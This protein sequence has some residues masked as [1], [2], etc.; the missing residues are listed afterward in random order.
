MYY[1]KKNLSEFIFNCLVYTFTG[2]LLVAAAKSSINLFPGSLYT[3]LLSASVWIIIFI[4]IRSGLKKYESE[5]FGFIERLLQRRILTFVVSLIGVAIAYFIFRVADFKVYSEDF[6]TDK[7]LF[8]NIRMYKYMM[9]SQFKNYMTENLFYASI[10]GFLLVLAVGKNSIRKIALSFSFGSLVYWI[11]TSKVMFFHNYYT[12]IIMITSSILAGF[13]FYLILSSLNT[14]LNKILIGGLLFLLVFPASFR[15]SVKSLSEYEDYSQAIEFIKNNTGE[16]DKLIYEGPIGP[17][18][19]YTRRSLI[20]PYRL[21]HD[22]LIKDIH[23]I[24]FADTMQKYGIKYLLSP[25]EKPKYIDYANLF[26][27]TNMDY[28]SSNRRYLILNTIGAVSKDLSDNY[29]K[30]DEIVHEHDIN[31]KFNLVEDFGKIKVYTF[32]N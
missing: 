18:A 17:I 14:K 5:I 27:N 13:A 23:D 22:K 6:L 31:N 8:F 7:Y 24:G 10:T 3:G 1:S 4:G 19:I 25:Y 15:E 28:P 20:R 11:L 9:L 16:K 29:S 21:D 12:L 26:I 2:L 32:R 30:L